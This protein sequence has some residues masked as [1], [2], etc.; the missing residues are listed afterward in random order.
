MTRKYFG[1]D[2]IRGRVG[3]P[4]ITADFAVRLGRD[5]GV[6]FGGGKLAPRVLIGKDPRSSGYML[7]A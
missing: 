7:E 4:P 1:T 6:V 3:T 2:G 5:A